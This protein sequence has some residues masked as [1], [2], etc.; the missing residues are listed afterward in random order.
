MLD[1]ILG[2]NAIEEGDQLC[3][4]NAAYNRLFEVTSLLDNLA[5]KA[6]SNKSRNDSV[7]KLK[8]VL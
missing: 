4:S 1:I 8:N 2:D 5:R 7:S 6:I 3:P